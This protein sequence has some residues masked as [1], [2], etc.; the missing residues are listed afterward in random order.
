MVEGKGALHVWQKHCITDS[1]TSPINILDYF[2]YRFLVE[3]CYSKVI[4]D[5]SSRVK[6]VELRLF[7]LI[8]VG[9]H[10]FASSVQSK[11]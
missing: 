5:R 11:L 10:V 9:G 2:W 6:A 8:A 4:Y 1:L 3:I 7:C